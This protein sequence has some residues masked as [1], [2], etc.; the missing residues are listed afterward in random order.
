MH[1]NSSQTRAMYLALNKRM[2]FQEKTK[3]IEISVLPMTMG[4][5]LL[6]YEINSPLL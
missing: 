5:D 6:T 1:Q 3:M 4:A 2:Y